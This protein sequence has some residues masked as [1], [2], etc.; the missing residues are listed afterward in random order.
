MADRHAIDSAIIK[1]AEAID[2]REGG[3]HGVLL[4]HGF[5]DTPQT[6]SLFARH[7]SKARLSVFVPLLPGHGRSMKAFTSSGA[8]EWIRAAEDAFLDMRRRYRVV[9]VSGLSMG[10]AL[11]VIIAARYR[12]IASLVLFAPYLGMARWMRALAMTHW[13]WGRVVGPVSASSPRS[14]HDP[15]EREKNLSYGQVT[16]RA[17]HEL[18]RVVRRARRALPSVVAP[19]LIIQSREDPRVSPAVAD[20]ALKRIGSTQKQIVWTSGAGHII[21][22]DYGRERLFVEAERWLL[23][24]AVRNATAAHSE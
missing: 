20:Y 23:S 21:T 11:A 18:A 16:G 6:L 17:I 22:V 19:T 10:G 24:H 15:I 5:G 13:A 2:L 7:L 3:S 12:E 14:I 4:L 8:D 1:G 9:S